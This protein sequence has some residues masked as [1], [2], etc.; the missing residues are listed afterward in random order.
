MD[1]L[2][3]PFCLDSDPD[4]ISSPFLFPP[5]YA[6]SH[7]DTQP[8]TYDKLHK[9]PVTF[10]AFPNLSISRPG[11]FRLRFQLIH[12]G[13]VEDTKQSLPILAEVWSDEF[14]VYSTQESPGLKD[15]SLLSDRLKELGISEIR[16]RKKEKGKRHLLY[17]S[18]V[19]CDEI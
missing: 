9:P 19:P 12:W 7:P 4:P 18:L 13:E 6:K 11:L 2:N 8:I 15:P 16:Y 14:R 5:S 10:F 3:A 1:L 17:D